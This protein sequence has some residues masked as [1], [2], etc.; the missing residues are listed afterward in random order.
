[1]NH[2]MGN[3]FSASS[4]GTHP[5]KVH[6]LAVEVMKELGVDIS[7]HRSKSIEEFRGKHFDIVVTVC[8]DAKE[9]CPFFPGKLVVHRSFPDPSSSDDIGVF[10]TVRDLIL[11]WI[12][13]FFGSTETPIPVK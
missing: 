3:R 5:S 1:M 2:F 13:D 7:H 8:D 4:A 10:R 11:D 12:L 9:T 6:P